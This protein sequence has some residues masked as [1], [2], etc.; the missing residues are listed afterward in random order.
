M[1]G[2]KGVE[3]FE[4]FFNFPEKVLLKKLPPKGGIKGAPSLTPFS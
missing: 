2:I 4:E 1:A 3:N